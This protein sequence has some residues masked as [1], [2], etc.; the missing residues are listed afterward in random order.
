MTDQKI[1]VEIIKDN[2][3]ELSRVF[4]ALLGQQ[5]FT[6]EKVNVDLQFN[7]KWAEAQANKTLMPSRPIVRYRVKS[8]DIASVTAAEDANNAPVVVLN[9]NL[10]DADGKSIEII[11]Q[12]KNTK[13]YNE[14]TV[15][16]VADAVKKSNNGTVVYFRNGRRLLDQ[17]NSLNQNE[18]SQVNAFVEDLK[19]QLDTIKST[20][21]INENKI[22][23][24]YKQLDGKP[25]ATEETHIHIENEQ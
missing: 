13:F 3:S 20:I 23:E 25:S 4:G 24:Y 2:R 8:I 21:T 18:A 9:Q 10:T 7:Q 12:V 11:C 6:I 16:S 14:V 22:N 5:I 15:Q 1:N 19:K 17:V